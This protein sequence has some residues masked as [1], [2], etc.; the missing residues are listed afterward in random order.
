MLKTNQNEKVKIL[1]N[2][3]F[4]PSLESDGRWKPGQTQPRIQGHVESQWTEDSWLYLI[5]E[6]DRV[7]RPLNEIE[8]TSYNV[9]SYGQWNLDPANNEQIVVCGTDRKSVV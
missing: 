9:Y 6:G 8:A 4:L 2:G 7:V 3:R 5:R 1:R